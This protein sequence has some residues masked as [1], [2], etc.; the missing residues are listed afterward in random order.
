[1][2]MKPISSVISTMPKVARSKTLD[3]PTSTGVTT[4]LSGT[5]TSKAIQRLLEVNNPLAVT[6]NLVSSVESILGSPINIVEKIT[7]PN[8]GGM[9][10]QL[11]RI[12]LPK[13]A[14]LQAIESA[15]IA[16]KQSLVGLPIK[17]LEQRL[18]VLM[19][20]L[21]KPAQENVDDLSI[22]I[23]SLATE[24]ANHPADIVVRAIDEIKLSLIHI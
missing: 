12:E 17:E 3:E 20:L 8:E 6:K 21:I 5:Q 7:Y 2:T 13:T 1:M 11:Q 22:R 10:V 23:R 16:V 9:R 15:T 4:E 18:A 19:S 14:T 24:L